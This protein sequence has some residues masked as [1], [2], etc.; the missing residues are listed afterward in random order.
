[1]DPLDRAVRRLEEALERGELTDKEYREEMRA[2]QDEQRGRAEEAAE[3]A[4]R[5][6]MGY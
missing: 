6:V 4:Y 5:D 3:S 1:M 2:L